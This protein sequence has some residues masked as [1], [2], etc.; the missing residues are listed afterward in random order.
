MMNLL[1]LEV[2]PEGCVMVMPAND[3]APPPLHVGFDGVFCDGY[4][5]PNLICVAYVGMGRFIARQS[6]G[7]FYLTH[8]AIPCGDA[9]HTLNTIKKACARKLEKDRRM[10]LVRLTRMM[11]EELDR[12]E[13]KHPEWT[14]DAVHAAGILSEESGEAMQA[15]VDFNATGD[16]DNLVCLESETIQTGAMCL[17]LLLNLEE[18]RQPIDAR[19]VSGILND[20]NIDD[21]TKLNL[22]QQ[23]IQG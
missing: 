6:T 16:R 1:L 15:A 17:R 5:M 20:A 10:R 7:K 12:A 14:S 4:V 21:A 23:L 11:V 3:I 9:E 2:L 13:L 8:M 19:T 22:I 18:F